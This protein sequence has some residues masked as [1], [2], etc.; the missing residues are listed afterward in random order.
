MAVRDALR[1]FP[2]SAPR[3]LFAPRFCGSLIAFPQIWS[4]SACLAIPRPVYR[5]VLT[6]LR[7]RAALGVPLSTLNNVLPG[8]RNG[9]VPDITV[10]QIFLNQKENPAN[11]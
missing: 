8:I 3:D 11:G 1:A 10:E 9:G 4:P 5:L 7:F 2:P 6:G